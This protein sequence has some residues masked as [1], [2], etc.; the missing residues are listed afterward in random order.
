MSLPPG[1]DSSIR[2]AERLAQFAIRLNKAPPLDRKQ[3]AESAWETNAPEIARLVEHGQ[4]LAETR[5]RDQYRG[6][7]TL[8]DCLVRTGPPGKHPFRGVKR[9]ELLE[10]RQASS[11]PARLSEAIESLQAVLDAAHR[12]AGI[13]R[14]RASARSQPH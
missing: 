6:L 4:S 7:E 8:G 11:L 13:A 12:V 5:Y 1:Q 14:G 2:D 10:E 9:I 3:I